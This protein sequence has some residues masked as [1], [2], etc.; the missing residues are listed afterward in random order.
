MKIEVECLLQ[1]NPELNPN[2]IAII[3]QLPT[4]ENPR[5]E[6]FGDIKTPPGVDWADIKNIQT[7]KGCSHKCGF[8]AAHSGNKI[9]FMPYIAVL[10]LAE[11]VRETRE[12]VLQ[13]K[14]NLFLKTPNDF[15]SWLNSVI[16]YDFRTPLGGFSFL[17]FWTRRC[18]DSED[19][20]NNRLNELCDLF[21]PFENCDIITTL[22]ENNLQ[23]AWKELDPIVRYA[24]ESKRNITNYYDS[25]PFDYR[26]NTFFHQNGAPADYGDVVSALGFYGFKVHITTAGWPMGSELA[27]TAVEKVVA[28]RNVLDNLRYSV[29]P[30]ERLAKEN[31][32]K[33]LNMILHNLRI[34]QGVSPKILLYYNDKDPAHEPFIEQVITP[35][36]TAIRN[37]ELKVSP[38][39]MSISNYSPREPQTNAATASH[40]VGFCMEGVH[41]WPNGEIY[42]QES[43]EGSRPSDHPLGR[44]W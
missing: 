29:N 24:L 37:E 22:S 41:V 25:E 12:K 19:S 42:K 4:V 18:M 38:A 30:T 44:A 43:H 21:S 32:K 23:A 11:K 35:L 2:L 31:L 27:T 17:I 6:L 14:K 9:E 39:R 16:Q 20:K 40:D 26:D 28:C 5:L 8:C 1:N 33:Y 10:K 34:F 15:F 7:T 13:E 36:D 3:Q